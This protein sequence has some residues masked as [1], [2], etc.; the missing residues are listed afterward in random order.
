MKK[1]MLIWTVLVICSSSGFTQVTKVGT[2][3]ANFLAIETG[4]RA[5]GMGGAYVAIAEGPVAMYWNPSGIARIDKFSTFFNQSKW[6]LDIS[7]NFI[8]AV[9]PFGDYGSLGVNAMFLSMDDMQITNESFPDGIENGF[10]SAGNYAFGVSYGF[11]LTDRFSIGFNAKYIEEFISQSSASAIAL[12]IG[13]LYTTEFDEMKI[14]MSI[15]NYGTKMQMSGNDLLVQ[16]DRYA[17][18]GNNPNINANLGTEEF[19]L[20]LIFRF[21]VS[22]DALKGEA[23]SNLLFALDAL[24]PN[25]NYQS[26]NLGVEYVFNNMFSLRSG[27]NTWYVDAGRDEIDQS[28]LSVGLGLKYSFGFTA[29]NIDYA[30]RDFGIL[31]DIQMFSFDLEF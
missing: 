3:V 4:A 19:D 7:Y 23:N 2:T 8:G 30:Y 22:W 9:L 6:L 24:V 27:Y 16:H 25:N 12:D 29:V 31:N 5:V 20:P 15:L 1:I 11:N 10:F 18:E 28:G 13:T 17:Q 21:G 14:G 26:M